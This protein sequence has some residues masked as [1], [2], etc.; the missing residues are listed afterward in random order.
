MRYV[1][2]WVVPKKDVSDDVPGLVE[3]DDSLDPLYAQVV[4]GTSRER[5][6]ERQTAIRLF[7]AADEPSVLAKL[8]ELHYDVVQRE[9]RP[10]ESKSFGFIEFPE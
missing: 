6:T 7:G 9:I 2:L 5:F 1:L 8:D 3:L 10:S 4:F